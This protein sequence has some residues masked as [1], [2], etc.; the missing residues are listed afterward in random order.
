MLFSDR[1]RRSANLARIVWSF[2]SS[3]HRQL[4]RVHRWGDHFRKR[5][6]AGLSQAASALRYRARSGERASS[7]LPESYALVRESARRTLGLFHYDVQ[8][9][10]AIAMQRGC[11]AEMRTGEGKTLT[12]TLVAYLMALTG[13]GVHM[14][15]ANDYLAARDAEWM[16][17]VFEFLGM[18]VGVVEQSTPRDQRRRAYGCD[19]TYGTAK[20][21]GFDFLRDRMAMRDASCARPS[22][23][24][25]MIGHRMAESRESL[26]RGHHFALVDEADH[27][28][29]DEAR[30]PLVVSS[31]RGEGNHDAALFTWAADVAS[32][33]T[34]DI[35]WTAS[36]SGGGSSGRQVLTTSGRQ[37]L[38]AAPRPEG[39]A[40]F[41]AIELIGAVERALSAREDYSRNRHYL[42]RG[43][44]AVL[45]DEATGRVSEG[46]KWRDGL[47]QAIEA[48]EGL[49]ITP[50]HR[51]AARITIQD[52]FRRYA[53]LAGMT[54]T[55]GGARRELRRVYRLRVAVIPTHRGTRRARLVPVCVANE[56]TKWTAVVA[57][58]RAMLESGRSVLIGTR[59]VGQSERLS[60]R[61][62]EAG[63]PHRVL[64]AR[65][66]AEE[67]AIVARA[68]Q[69]DQVTVATNMA[70]RGT[71]ILVD[72]AVLRRGGL[73]V[74]ATEFHESRRI[75]H[76]LIG[77]CGRQGEPGSYRQFAAS[78]DEIL[79]TAF[80]ARRAARI[81]KSLGRQSAERAIRWFRR[82][83][84]R[85]ERRHATERL[86]LMEHEQERARAHEQ[87]GLDPY[88]DAPA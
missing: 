4:A 63:V 20:E 61:L 35:D 12:A 69:A 15:T 81:R 16:R 22:M 62:R 83:Q 38:R 67:A 47:H 71:D 52:Y 73:H 39:L 36:S 86:W 53:R 85:I 30:T 49:P 66:P 56:E 75:D 7:L 11:V 87:M 19:V 3:D 70:G 37:R 46:R 57:E 33:L 68:G 9:L 88:L 34:P 21:F 2:A 64:N 84:S 79:E 5:D 32:R 28:L 27:I 10:G 76:Q 24:A 82:A 60:E 72:D 13:D 1:F 41:D 55:T 31:A 44:E 74:I 8:V 65:R 78:D 14:A 59:S 80:G 51:D 43:D 42:V 58:T 29:L 40:R 25:R 45:V 6:D 26:Q 18:T 23:L 48:K 77:R 50:T 54:G 17:P